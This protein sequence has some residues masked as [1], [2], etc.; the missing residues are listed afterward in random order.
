MS[1]RAEPPFFISSPLGSTILG[2]LHF[3]S[4]L[5]GDLVPPGRRLSKSATFLNASKGSD[6]S[7]R[8]QV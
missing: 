8:V 4:Y 6:Q 2:P 3:A 5:T 1:E 7:L